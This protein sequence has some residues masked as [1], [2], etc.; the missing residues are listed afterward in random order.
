M[1]GGPGVGKTTIIRAL[2]DIFAAK[3]LRVCLAA[4]TGRAAKRLEEATGRPAMTLHRLLKFMPATG[5]FEHS[6]ANPLAGDVFILDE[7]SMIDIVLMNQFLA[8]L[9]SAAR[10]VLVGDPD[11]LPSVGPGNVLRDCLESGALPAAALTEIFRQGARRWIVHNAHRVNTGLVLEAPPAGE[12]SDFFVVEHQDPESIVRAAVELVT[13]RIP[14]R[15]GLNPRTDIQVLTPM[16]R[17][18]LGADNLNVVLQE[19]L[20]PAGDALA[21]YGRLYRAGDRVMQLRNNYDKDVYNGDIGFV[22]ALDPEAQTL[23]VEFDG[24][25]VAYEAHELDELSLAYASTIHKAQGS[26]HPAV[27]VL[28]ATQHYA[29][30]QRNLLYTALT[31]GRRLVCLV[32]SAKA[33]A[34]A[35]GN[36][37]TI[38]RRTRLRQRLAAPRLPAR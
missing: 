7:V 2:V 38:E 9:P 32:G 36:N 11:Q 17:F 3:S 18:Q 15:F 20:N 1:T 37:R 13:R 24:R 21:R 26:E 35:I 19:A 27:V 25:R 33:V 12:L 4:P 29:L 28:M 14:Q 6:P 10:L 22:S 30:L 8:A 31:R 34:L 23:E 5:R 16:R